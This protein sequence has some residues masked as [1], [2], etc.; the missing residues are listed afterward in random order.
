V[1]SRAGAD[2]AR[3]KGKKEQ[4]KGED[5]SVPRLGKWGGVEERGPNSTGPVEVG[6][7]VFS[8]ILSRAAVPGELKSKGSEVRRHWRAG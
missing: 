4:E 7:L 6:R 3:R 8:E 2:G 1:D 5:E